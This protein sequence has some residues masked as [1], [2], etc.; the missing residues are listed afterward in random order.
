M[1]KTQKKKNTQKKKKTQNV[2]SK[3][4]NKSRKKTLRVVHKTRK[5]NG[6]S[7][8]NSKR[9]RKNKQNGGMVRER[10]SVR[11]L[12]PLTNNEYF[13]TL[14]NNKDKEKEFLIDFSTKCK[15]AEEQYRIYK[16]SK[17]AYDG[18]NNI[19]NFIEKSKKYIEE[20]TAL[21]FPDYES[22]NFKENIKKQLGENPSLENIHEIIKF[23]QGIQDDWNT[24]LKIT[25]PQFEEDLNSLDDRLALYHSVN[26]RDSEIKYIL[27]DL[28]LIKNTIYEGAYNTPDSGAKY[29]MN[30]IQQTL[31]NNM[32][33]NKL[34]GETLVQFC[35]NIFLL[36]E[37][38]GYFKLDVNSIVRKFDIVKDDG[39]NPCH[40]MKEN[41]F[42][43]DM[44]TAKW[45]LKEIKELDAQHN[46]PFI[47]EMLSNIELA[48]EHLKVAINER[49]LWKSHVIVK[50]IYKSENDALAKAKAI[51]KN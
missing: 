26:P 37:H 44:K 41:N 32:D 49:D 29:L 6:K 3:N 5:N 43:R 12:S 14:Y 25:E 50:F 48:N 28:Q 20:H 17:M 45:I 18:L 36:G 47:R 42:N 4:K 9:S 24:F 15:L 34:Q 51:N 8:R 16:P 11:E 30:A 19:E 38:I 27:R 22:A 40:T 13:K 21:V 46:D 1:K 33:N 35:N 39:P 23:G 31:I 2:F 10:E 7:K